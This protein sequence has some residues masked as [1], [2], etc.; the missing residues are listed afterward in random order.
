MPQSGIFYSQSHAFVLKWSYSPNLVEFHAGMKLSYF[1]DFARFFL[2][3]MKQYCVHP[4]YNA[5]MKT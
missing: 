4:E 1:N 3:E 2:Y 5:L